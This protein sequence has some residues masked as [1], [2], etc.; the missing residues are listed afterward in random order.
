MVGAACT[1]QHAGVATRLSAPLGFSR[2]ATA[3]VRCF[4]G[5]RR[6]HRWCTRDVPRPPRPVHGSRPG[7][8]GRA[9]FPCVA[10][11][12]EPWRWGASTVQAVRVRQ[13]GALHRTQPANFHSG[14]RAAQH[15]AERQDHHLFHQ[16][17]RRLV[18]RTFQRLV[19]PAG[20]TGPGPCVLGPA[21]GLQATA[22]IVQG[23]SGCRRRACSTCAPTGSSARGHAPNA[24]SRSCRARSQAPKPVALK[25]PQAVDVGNQR[26][27]R[28]MLRTA[29]AARFQDRTF[30]TQRGL[31]RLSNAAPAAAKRGA[32][33]TAS[34]TS[35][36]KASQRNAQP[37][38]EVAP[39]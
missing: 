38:H 23:S 35:S 8:A 3:P 22:P 16:R 18:A 17:I 4:A 5:F 21:G 32:V 26:H 11:G 20:S 1:A 37:G 39:A 10:R 6:D 33:L 30:V 36:V 19:D 25:A 14:K 34:S 2:A 15:L 29:C 9:G 13:A 7:A 12:Q 28:I 31:G 24:I 27:Q